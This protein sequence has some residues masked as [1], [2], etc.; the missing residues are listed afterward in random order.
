MSDNDITTEGC[1]TCA[2]AIA[3]GDTSG[4][5]QW[6]AAAFEAETEGYLATVD[7]DDQ[8]FSMSD[9]PLCGALA[10]DRMTVTLTPR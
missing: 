2:L 1:T 3:N 4:D 9:C 6:D 7:L 5:D 8:W 10:G